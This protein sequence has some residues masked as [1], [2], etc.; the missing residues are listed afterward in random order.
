[1]RV[2]VVEDDQ[3]LAAIFD[4][5]LREIGHEPS[6]VHT[7]EAALSHVYADPPDAVLLD[8]HLPGMSGLEFL[9]LAHESQVPVV[10]VSGV[11]TERQA[12]ECLR[13][14]A[15]DFLAKPVALDRLKEIFLL[16]EPHAR[17]RPLETAAP[18]VRGRRH[19]RASV[20][21][22]VRVFEYNGAEWEAT[23]VNLSA[24][25]IKI[26][27]AQPIQ[28]GSAVKLAFSP[29]D[30]NARLEVMSLLVRMDLDGLA[31]Y[32]VNLTETQLQ[33][34]NASVRRVLAPR[35]PPETRP[36]ATAP[37]PVPGAESESVPQPVARHR[38]HWLFLLL[39]LGL[40]LVIG[41]AISIGFFLAGP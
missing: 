1:M 10:A 3:T 30:G 11:V 41:A 9:A 24:S 6:V 17:S 40:A 16:L 23:A 26:R 25:G 4:E 35:A 27:P 13:L 8:I 22:P 29:P 32:F 20:A 5:F 15:F 18:G 7:A 37:E 34:L 21:L 31:F 28:P 14:G 38:L 2:L 39:G 36:A 12:R 19:Q 33:R